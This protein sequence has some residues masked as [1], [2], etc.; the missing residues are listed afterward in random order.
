MIERETD[1]DREKGKIQKD[2]NKHEVKVVGTK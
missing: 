2:Q 1:T